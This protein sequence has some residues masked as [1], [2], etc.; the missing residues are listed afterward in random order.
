MT[1]YTYRKLIK[2]VKSFVKPYKKQFLLGTFLRVTSDIV[3]L[4]PIW[5]FGEIITFT[6]RF[7][8]GDSTRPFWLLMIS[9]GG[10]AIYHFF[11]HDLAKYYIY[12]VAE[13][14]S[15]DAQLKSLKHMFR[16][17]I[18]W[19]EKENTGNKIRRIDHGGNGFN[20]IVRLYV[21][22]LI[23]STISLIGISIIFYTLS[24][25]HNAILLFFFISYFFISLFFSKKAS[26]QSYITNVEWEKFSG[27]AFESINNI[28]TIKSLNLGKRISFYL[29]QVA[30]RLKGE[31]KKRIIWFR[32]RQVALN[33]YQEFFRQLIVVYT[34]ICVFR[35]DLEVG[36]I[37]MVLLYFGKI[38]ESAGEFAVVANELILSKIDIMRMKDI[39]NEKATIEDSGYKSFNKNWK[40]LQLKDVHFQY[41][42][43]KVLKNFSLDIKRGEKVGI[44]GLSGAGKSTL[45]K[46][47][48]KLYNDYDGDIYF[49]K[50]KLRDVKRTTF[51]DRIAVVPQDT[52]LF[53]FS[54]REN[55]TLEKKLHS[56]QKKQLSHAFKVAHVDDFM[57]KLPKGIESYIGEKGVKLS[58]GEKQRVGI[59][60]A[61][62]RNPDIL[63]LDEAT[64]HLDI[65]SEKKIQ[66]ALHQF[67]KE[68]TAIVIAH[69]LTTIKEMDKIVI[70]KDGKMEE[71]GS[72]EELM[73]KK[74][75]F[76]KL[77]KKQKF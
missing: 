70:I 25:Q 34:V 50:T 26:K 47:L 44:V 64:S 49:D 29:V 59:A 72:F 19:H 32:T 67:F 27:S 31:I 61:V 6:T 66:D 8:I 30:R 28:S 7:S 48:L 52:E 33:M 73:K 45:I 62:Y 77:W 17:N 76:Y 74:G 42:G 51:L 36:V 68:T 1:N 9:I 46:L 75:E 16:L 2:D 39:L 41:K 40:I 69:R 15:I 65:E 38:R 43:R 13:K 60:R 57:H 3:W 58:G 4:F 10:I 56:K 54:L 12:Q 23:E 24:W 22:L 21:D 55:I 11:A 53:N 18:D 71:Q 5:A 37:A 14:V 20:T 63:L 35:G